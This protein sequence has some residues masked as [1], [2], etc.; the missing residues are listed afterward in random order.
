MR[1][2]DRG[3][4][5]NGRDN[6]DPWLCAIALNLVIDLQRRHKPQSLD[7]QQQSR[8]QEDLPLNEIVAITGAPLPTVKSRLYRALEALR[9]G[10]QEYRRGA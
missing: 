1:V 2:L 5:Y 3:D 4:S 6:F 10:V 9:R 7:C 8:F